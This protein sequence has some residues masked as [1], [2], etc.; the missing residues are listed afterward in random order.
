MINCSQIQGPAHNSVSIQE[1]FSVK[2]TQMAKEAGV[3]SYFDL[4]TWKR[5][6][7]FYKAQKQIVEELKGYTVLARVCGGDE[8]A[9]LN[10]IIGVP[11]VLV[12]GSC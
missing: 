7:N 12:I 10:A 5:R 2:S 9:L 3:E 1:V 8:Q 4:D 11:G 6:D